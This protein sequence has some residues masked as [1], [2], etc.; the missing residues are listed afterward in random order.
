MNNR[1]IIQYIFRERIRARSGFRP[2]KKWLI[3][4]LLQKSKLL[5]ISSGRKSI[6]VNIIFYCIQKILHQFVAKIKILYIAKVC[7]QTLMLSTVNDQPRPL[8]NNNNKRI[9]I[10]IMI[11]SIEAAESPW[12]M[13]WPASN[14]DS[15][16]RSNN[17]F[18]K[19]LKEVDIHF[20]F[21]G[22][23]LRPV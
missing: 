2:L 17:K 10:I 18:M 7:I 23:F 15:W 1:E 11:N 4:H 13:T 8:A 3:R 19:T 21:T 14:L 12:L 6:S 16:W 9:L 5:Y 22:S 20:A